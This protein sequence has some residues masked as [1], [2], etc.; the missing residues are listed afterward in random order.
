MFRKP[1]WQ[2]QG[3][4]LLTL[5]TSLPNSMRDHCDIIKWCHDHLLYF[6]VGKPLH[7]Q[8]NHHSLSAHLPA[9]PPI[10]TITI[11]THKPH[12]LFLIPNFMPVTYRLVTK[13]TLWDGSC[14][15]GC[16][17]MF[18]APVCL[19][20]PTCLDAPSMLGHPHMFR[21]PLHMFGYPLYV[22]TPHVS[23]P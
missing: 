11:A 9:S 8:R 17:H 21:H 3:L 19:V 4:C 15:F 1:R 23:T 2:P 10:F 20:T 13:P 6:F 16:P 18:D 12:H 22:W 7:A 14:M 5:Y